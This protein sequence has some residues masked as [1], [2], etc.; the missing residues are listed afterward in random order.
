MDCSSPGLP[1]PPVYCQ[2]KAVMEIPPGSWSL[3]LEVPHLQRGGQNAN[4]FVKTC[5]PRLQRNVKKTKD[6]FGKNSASKAWQEPKSCRWFPPNTHLSPPLPRGRRY[7]RRTTTRILE[8]A[9]PQEIRL[10]FA[11]R[12]SH[13][14]SSL[15]EVSDVPNVRFPSGLLNAGLPLAFF[16][17]P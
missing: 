4:H 10:T 16:S 5:V 8:R 6:I 15:P 12:S 13:P 2:K 3:K 9:S 11:S 14:K 7:R 17:K 1:L